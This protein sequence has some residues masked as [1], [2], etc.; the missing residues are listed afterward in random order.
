MSNPFFS[1]FGSR[2]TK[3]KSLDANGLQ[4]EPLPPYMNKRIIELLDF[5]SIGSIREMIHQPYQA[6]D[7]NEWIADNCV[8]FF[9]LINCLYGTIS[10][11]CTGDKCP[12]MNAPG[13]VVYYWN[14][15]KTKKDVKISAQK[16]IDLALSFIQNCLNDSTYMPLKQT[17]VFPANFEQ[18]VRRVLKFEWQILSH[19]FENHLDILNG[20]EL[21]PHLYSVF[22]HFWLFNDE[23][24]LLDD[25]DLNCLRSLAEFMLMQETCDS[26]GCSDEIIIPNNN[27]ENSCLTQLSSQ[28]AH[29][30]T[31]DSENRVKINEKLDIADN[32]ENNFPLTQAIAGKKR[33]ADLPLPGK[34]DRPVQKV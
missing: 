1:L 18:V 24:K 9:H 26:S 30:S 13:G 12:V 34:I 32:N 14:D 22:I 6:M 25:E 33:T 19:M 4:E 10:E 3:K 7:K 31:N 11:D 20:Y 29:S 28:F 21:C 17:D 16:Y 15:M 8:S 5:A 2:K 23:F 27:N